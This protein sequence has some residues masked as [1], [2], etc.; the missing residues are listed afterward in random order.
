MPMIE[1]PEEESLSRIPDLRIAQRKFTLQHLEP[2]N[3]E[4]KKQLMEDIKT[5]FMAPFYKI[6]CKD[7]GWAEDQSLTKSLEVRKHPNL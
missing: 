5:N 4:I 3:A 7:L 6:C 1:K 2:K